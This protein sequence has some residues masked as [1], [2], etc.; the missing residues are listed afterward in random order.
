MKF[1]LP[2][3]LLAAAMLASC[4]GNTT[5][6]SEQSTP[7]TPESSQTASHLYLDWVNDNKIVI[8]LFD[9]GDAKFSYGNAALSGA[10]QTLDLNASAGISCS[11][12]LTQE[13]T[14]NF[15]VVTEAPS[16][17]GFNAGAAVYPGIEG[18]QLSEF[19]ADRDDLQGKTRAYVA[20]SFGETVKWAKNH[21]ADMDAKIQQL[22]DAAK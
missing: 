16:S 7:A 2:L 4:G 8:D 9:I 5:P 19:L 11:T 12:T 20:I 1:K 13:T 21:N 10:T 22:I 14:V 17:T 3:F 6:S 15:I 18:D